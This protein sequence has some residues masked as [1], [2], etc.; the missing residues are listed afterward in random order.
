MLRVKGCLHP[1]REV[2]EFKVI[3]GATSCLELGYLTCI[4]YP[5]PEPFVMVFK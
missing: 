3:P 1:N 2:G 4:P 5:F